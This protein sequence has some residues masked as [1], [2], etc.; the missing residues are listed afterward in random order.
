LFPKTFSEIKGIKRAMGEM[1]IELKLGSN[2][3]RHRPYHLNPAVKEKVKKEIDKMLEDKR[4]TTFITKWGSFAYNV[5]SFSLKSTPAVFSRIVIETFQEFI[6]KFI[7]VYMDDWI[8]Y[9][10]LKEHVGLLRLMFDICREFPISLNLRKCIFCVP[11]GNLL[12]HIVY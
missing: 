7:E 6:H 4:K 5:M 10:L 3:I 12:G 8:V 1:K 11:H 2:P 9:N